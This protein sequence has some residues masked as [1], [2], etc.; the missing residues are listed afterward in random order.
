MAQPVAVSNTTPLIALAWLE[1]LDLLP[2][3][4]GAVH[5]PE[6]FQRDVAH[7]QSAHG[8]V[9][10]QGGDWLCVTRIRELS[11]VE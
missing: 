10:F 1:R 8:P 9:A 3:I 6:V 11:A 7:Y 2:A 4:F 5:I